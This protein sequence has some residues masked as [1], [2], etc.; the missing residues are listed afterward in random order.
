MAASHPELKECCEDL[1]NDGFRVLAIAYKDVERK[2][3]YSKDDEHNLVLVGC[4]DNTQLSKRS[5]KRRP[6]T[7]K[8]FAAIH[9]A[10]H[11]GWSGPYHEYSPV[12]LPHR[13]VWQSEYITALAIQTPV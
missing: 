2:A 1:G 12:P 8:N 9:R 5:L 13:C 10:G 11:G 7:R 3:A 4:V 6:K